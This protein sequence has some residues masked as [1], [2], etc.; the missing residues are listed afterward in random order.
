MIYDHFLASTSIVNSRVYR[1]LLTIANTKC[2][3]CNDLKTVKTLELSIE[4]LP[5][6]KISGVELG[7]LRGFSPLVIFSMIL[8][9]LAP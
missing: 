8:G 7:G 5:N 6:L 9:A 2:R 3:T 4:A 1:V